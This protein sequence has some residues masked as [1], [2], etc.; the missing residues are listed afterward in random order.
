[1]KEVFT[2]KRCPVCKAVVTDVLGSTDNMTC[3]GAPLE[4]LTANTTDAA[5]E[6]HVPAV[7]IIDGDI[8][9]KVGSVEHPMTKEHYIMWVSQVCD[10]KENKVV[11]FPKTSDKKKRRR[12][13]TARILSFPLLYKLSKAAVS[14]VKLHSL[15][16]RVKNGEDICTGNPSD[17][18]FR[19]IEVIQA[20]PISSEAEVYD[21]VSNGGESDEKV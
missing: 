2:Y 12:K 19:S 16:N 4:T 17:G 15:T 5:V 3:C 1:M 14:Q 18:I 10:N 21:I 8:V 13:R 9:V 6:K 11:L 20:E 7:E